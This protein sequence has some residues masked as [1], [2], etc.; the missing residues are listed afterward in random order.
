M[1]AIESENTIPLSQQLNFSEIIVESTYDGPHIGTDGVITLEFVHSLIEYFKNQKL[2]HR[3]YVMQI[4]IAAKE[5]FEKQPTLLR[6]SLPSIDGGRKGHFRVCGDTHGQYF[7]LCNIFDI[8]GF[9]STENPFLFN[10]D[11]V[12]RGSFSFEVVLTLFAIKLWNPLAINMLRG[13]H[14]TKGMNKIYGFEGEVKH[15]YDQNVFLLFGEVFC[16]LPLCAVIHDAVFVVHGGLSTT[17]DGAIT[18]DE[19][20]A[21]NR[22]REPVEGGLMSDLLWSGE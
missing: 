11:F 9:P 16:C 6:L 21:I 3:K 12:D 1:Q 13:N 5:Y 7:D 15:K 20:N 10:G 2:L 14:E 17:N 18:L 22:F 4:L 8:G 19:I